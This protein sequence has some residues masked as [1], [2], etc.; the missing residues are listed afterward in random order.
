MTQNLQQPRFGI[1]RLLNMLNGD[2]HQFG[3]AQPGVISG[4]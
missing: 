3:G 2:R 1:D 4:R